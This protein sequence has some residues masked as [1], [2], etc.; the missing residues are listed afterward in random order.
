MLSFL[1]RNA[2]LPYHHHLNAPQAVGGDAHTLQ[3]QPCRVRAAAN[4]YEANVGFQ[5]RRSAFL[6]VLHRKLHLKMWIM[7]RSENEWE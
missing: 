1:K 7:S 5:H 3:P 2:L 6:H 4:G